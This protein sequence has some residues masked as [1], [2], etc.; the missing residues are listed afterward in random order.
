MCIIQ[1]RLK[2]NERF[3][4]FFLLFNVSATSDRHVPWVYV[5]HDKDEKDYKSLSQK[6]SSFCFLFLI[7]SQL[8]HNCISCKDT[9]LKDI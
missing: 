1:P 3:L 4:Q 9:D 6:A 7:F 2:N 5:S 8:L